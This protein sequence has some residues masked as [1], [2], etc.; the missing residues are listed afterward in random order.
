MKSMR[1]PR[2]IQPNPKGH[3]ILL[4]QMYETSLLYLHRHASETGC[5]ARGIV[6]IATH[7]GSLMSLQRSYA[8]KRLSVGR[9]HEARCEVEI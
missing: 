9:P 8:R 1:N 4:D 3:D 6:W 5:V 7:D 2:R